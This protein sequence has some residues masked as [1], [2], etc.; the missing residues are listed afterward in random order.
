MGFEGIPKVLAGDI[1]EVGALRAEEPLWSPVGAVAAFLCKDVGWVCLIGRSAYL[2]G[3]GIR[4]QE[5]V[6]QLPPMPGRVGGREASRL[7][8]S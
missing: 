7:A 4:V 1:E 5:L 6:Y 3:D 8:D 2:P